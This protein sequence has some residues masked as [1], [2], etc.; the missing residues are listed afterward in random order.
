VRAVLTA[1]EEKEELSSGTGHRTSLD[2]L[3]S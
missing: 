1:L 2:H 3:L